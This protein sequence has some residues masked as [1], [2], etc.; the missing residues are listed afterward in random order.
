MAYLLAALLVKPGDELCLLM[1]NTIVKDL[2]SENAF[3]VM[4][5]LTLL[6]YFLSDS[7]ITHIIPI[8]RKLTKH[9][10]AIISRK[11]YLVLFNIH[12]AYG[13][14]LPDIKSLA[15]EALGSSEPPVMFAG[16]SMVYSVVVGNP[17]QNKELTKRLADILKDILEHKYPK[18]Y[19]YHR[20]PAPW[21][22]VQLLKM[23]EA[24]GR[25]DQ[26]ASALIY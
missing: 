4:T 1:N 19:D 11:S 7:L 3:V 14:H 10:T 12:Q 13:A 22:Q 8:L 6:R 21:S 17:H 15:V 26:Q 24:L 16:L 18:E 9:G 23:L 5:A 20:I 2:Q 25:N